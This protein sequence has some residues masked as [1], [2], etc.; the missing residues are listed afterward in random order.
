MTPATQS[1]NR[2]AARV[3]SSLQDL[4]AQQDQVLRRSQLRELGFD[5]NAVQSQVRAGRWARAGSTVVVL[6]T[7]PLSRRQ[8]EWAAVLGAGPHSALAGRTGL[9]LAGLQ[10][11]DDGAVHVVVPRGYSPSRVPSVRTIFH[12]TRCPPERTLETVGRPPRTSVE[13]SAIDAAVWSQRTATAC[14]VL[15][16]VVQQRLSTGP[17]LLVALEQ[18]GAVKHRAAMMRALRDISGGAQ[19][20]TEINFGR[21]SRRHELGKVT[22]QAVRLDGEGR[23]RY[24][25]VEIESAAGARIWCEIDG[26]VHLLAMNYWQDM[27]R[28]NELLIAGSP[29]LRFPSIA[30]YVDEL[31]VVDQIRRAHAAAEARL[32]HAA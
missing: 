14:G 11:W 12:E 17:R 8:R 13:R 3:T 15:A 18:A 31:R 23:R 7:G 16:A 6:H 25:D 1:Q 5:R 2:Q 19:A 27:S 26:A 4:A 28:S 10:G 21:L 24:L 32:R 20:L 9:A 22:H 29:V 30:M